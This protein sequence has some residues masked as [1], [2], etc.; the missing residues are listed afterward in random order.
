MSGSGSSEAVSG[1]PAFLA[2]TRREVVRFFRQPSRIIASIGTPALLWL[3]MAGGFADSFAPPAPG[4]GGADHANYAAYLLPGMATA[5]VLFSSI[6][7]A[8]SL[9]E[10]RR[11]GFLQ[12]ALVSP[13]P[14][15]AIVGAKAA[16]GSIIATA[17]SV[18]VIA[19]APAVGLHPGVVGFVMALAALALTS[20]ALT[21]LGLAAAWW[22]NSSEGFH[23]VMNLVLMPMWLLSG[24]FF[25]AAGASKWLAVVMLVNP[26][27][28][29]TD[30]VR[31]PL[32]GEWGARGLAWMGTV[33]FAGGMVVVASLVMGRS[34][35]RGWA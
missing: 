22:V 8:M 29:A 3:F 31:A 9:I 5:V 11:E 23:G 19:A 18:I 17:Q 34:G 27:S 30:A 20:V 13:A 12:S 21:S 25:P 1:V 35:T 32:S 33:L 16:G 15:W 10:D 2:L 14:A 26:L 28:W 24:A 4:A 7:T 6:F